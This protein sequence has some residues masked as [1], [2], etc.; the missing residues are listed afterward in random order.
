MPFG[1]VDL[2]VVAK[3]LIERPVISFQLFGFF[4]EGLGG[5]GKKLSRMGCAVLADD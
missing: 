2:V 3:L 1:R 4:K 5:G